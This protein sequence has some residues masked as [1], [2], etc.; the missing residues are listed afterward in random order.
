MCS[1][2]DAFVISGTL[3]GSVSCEEVMHDLEMSEGRTTPKSD[4]PSP[5]V[6]PRSDVNVLTKPTEYEGRANCILP[7]FSNV[8]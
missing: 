3:N 4:D 5:I 6:V 8:K 7:T 1:T 2:T